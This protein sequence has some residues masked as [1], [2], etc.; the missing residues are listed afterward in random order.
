[1]CLALHI[2]AVLDKYEKCCSPARFDPSVRETSS[3]NLQIC[4]G[5]A[6]H[7][8]DDNTVFELQRRV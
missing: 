3:E 2:A 5:I 8:H 4:A 7:C 6:Q 1:M